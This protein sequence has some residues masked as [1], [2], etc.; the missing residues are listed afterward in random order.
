[1]CACWKEPENLYKCHHPLWFDIQ[2]PEAKN[3]T[4]MSFFFVQTVT[5]QIHIKS[6]LYVLAQY[7]HPVML[8]EG[9]SD[10]HQPN[11]LYFAICLRLVFVLIIK[12]SNV[13][14][15]GNSFLRNRT[16]CCA[17]HLAGTETLVSK[18]TG[19][20]PH[21]YRSIIIVKLCIA[22]GLLF[23]ISAE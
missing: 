14:W 21:F 2:A 23:K 1:M 6:F 20:K 18:I 8:V 3:L 19:K 22:M 12:S 17:N 15:D 4:L 11:R 7:L 13:D 10:S 5:S 16:V 9:T